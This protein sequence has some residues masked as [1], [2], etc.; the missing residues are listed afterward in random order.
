M[1]NVVNFSTEETP[2]LLIGP[3]EVYHVVVDGRIVPNLTG[4]KNHDGSV[5]LVVDRRFCGDFPSEKIAFQAA[6][7]IAESM[8][9]TAGYSHFAAETKDQPFAPRSVGLAASAPTPEPDQ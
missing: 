6:W 1:D 2:P 5:S 3:F 7:L 9:I 4:R 8:A